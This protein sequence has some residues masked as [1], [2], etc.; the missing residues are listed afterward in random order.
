MHGNPF[1]GIK[2]FDAAHCAPAN[3]SDRAECG[4]RVVHRDERFEP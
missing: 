1:P 4:A 2:A 3:G